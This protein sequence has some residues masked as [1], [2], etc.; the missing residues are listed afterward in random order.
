MS[1]FTYEHS[2]NNT[3]LETYEWDNTW[4]EQ[5]NLCDVKRVLYIGDSISCGIRK[6]ATEQSQG[7]YLF[8]GFGSSKALDHPYLAESIRLFALQENRRDAVLFNNGLHGWHLNDEEEYGFYFER[9][10]QFLMKE[11]QG[12]PLYLVLTTSVQ[13]EAREERVKKRNAV[14][15]ELAK[16]YGLKLIDLYSAS[17]S[18]AELRVDGV[19]FSRDG[20]VR[21]ADQIL[22]EIKKG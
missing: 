2:E 11:Y 3:K 4:L 20:Y 16:K 18:C 6:I 15:T 22:T 14:V 1:F 12:V 9:A 19:H 17:V 21:L 5:S 13:N 8:D 7:E 10:I